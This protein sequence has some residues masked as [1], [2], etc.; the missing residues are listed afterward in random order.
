MLF[1]RCDLVVE[2][3]GSMRVLGVYVR[4]VVGSAAIVTALLAHS[5]TCL[6]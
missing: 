5:S 2:E 1:E 3:R 4:V 6:T